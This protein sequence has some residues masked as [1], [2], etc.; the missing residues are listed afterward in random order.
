MTPARLFGHANIKVELLQN[1]SV[2]FFVVKK[3]FIAAAVSFDY[4]YAR[5]V[6]RLAF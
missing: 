3:S 2:T 4:V 6:K 1:A 5:H